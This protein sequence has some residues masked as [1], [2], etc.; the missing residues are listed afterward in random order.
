MISFRP[1]EAGPR[2]LAMLITNKII[3]FALNPGLPYWVNFWVV[4]IV[5]I[6]VAEMIYRWMANAGGQ[7][8]PM[9]VGRAVYLLFI[10]W[11]TAAV[12]INLTTTPVFVIRSDNASQY[13]MWGQPEFQFSDGK[14]IALGGAETNRIGS[15]SLL[16]RSMIVNDSKWDVR[17]ETVQYGRGPLASSNALFATIR[18][19]TALEVPAGV[20]YFGPNHSPPSTLALPSKISGTVR[21]WVTW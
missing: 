15:D 16:F 17:F 2:S 7:R 11:I 10:L 1:R 13:R 4:V 18:P 21:H 9:T 5:S 12:V 14:T 6:V 3:L 19:L 8:D 20:D